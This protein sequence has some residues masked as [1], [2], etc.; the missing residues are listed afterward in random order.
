MHRETFFGTLPGYSLT[1]TVNRNHLGV[2]EVDTPAE[3][4][5]R[6]ACHIDVV[7]PL[8]VN[9]PFDL[10]IAAPKLHGRLAIGTAGQDR[11]HQRRARPGAASESLSRTALP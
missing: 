2:A 10:Q 4:L 7:G 9:T 8:A 6:I 3:D 1:A 5:D 11:G